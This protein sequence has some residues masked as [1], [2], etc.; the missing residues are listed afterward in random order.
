MSWFIS[1][2]P[3]LWRYAFLLEIIELQ[4]RLMRHSI[5]IFMDNLIK[6]IEFYRLNYVWSMGVKY[7]LRFLHKTCSQKDGHRHTI[8]SLDTIFIYPLVQNQFLHNFRFRGKNQ[9]WHCHN[10]IIASYFASMIK[11]KLLLKL[12]TKR[13]CPSVRGLIS[14]FSKSANSS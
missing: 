3:I 11:P 12:E 13:R 6:K 1:T 10:E 5:H 4:K 14:P 8:S 7:I 2:V 9:L